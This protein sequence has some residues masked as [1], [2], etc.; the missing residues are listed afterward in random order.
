MLPL[1]LFVMSSCSK[2]D[3][4]L[5]DNLGEFN[6][7]TIQHDGVERTY[8][9]YLPNNFNKTNAS[10]LVLALHGGG[11]TGSRFEKDVS[12][13]S[14]TAAAE[15]RGMVL[16]TPNG[17]DKRWNDGRTEHF[18][19]D[20]MY[21][22]VGFISAVIDRMIEDYGVDS[23]RV[24]ATGISNGGLMSFRL[25]LDL[26]DKIAAIAPVTA[27]VSK[28]VESKV[29]DFPVSLMLVNGVDD[30]LVPYDGGCIDVPLSNQ[31]RGEVLSTDESIAK[32]LDFNQCATLAETEAIID[33]LPNDGTSVE[34]TRYNT[35]A[36]KADVVLIKVIGG[37]HT[38]P[39]GAQYLPPDL[40]GV[41]SSEINAS[42]MILDFFL[43]HTRN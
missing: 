26:S 35:C 39:G 41:V 4:A 9:M 30:P 31:C 17:I 42:E 22:D 7:K 20:S 1:F 12:E 40:V 38:W 32:F 5:T 21:D 8:H 3:D 19:G 36:D 29:P 15:A 10:P 28:A 33:Q 16:V 18:G 34:I 23:N 24:Y 27:Q 37:G 25:A 43:S 2:D 14:L 6:A 11:G 13:G